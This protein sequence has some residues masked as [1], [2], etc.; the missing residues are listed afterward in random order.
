[1]SKSNKLKDL[2]DNAA[3]AG[4]ITPHTSTLLSGNLG[5]VVIAGAAGKDTLSGGQGNDLLDPCS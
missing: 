2:F 1:M 5:A 3:S 4:V